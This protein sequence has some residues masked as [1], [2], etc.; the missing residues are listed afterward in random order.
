MPCSIVIPCYNSEKSVGPLVEQLAA[1]DMDCEVILVDDNSK[2]ET[3]ARIRE[4]T[5]KHDF[6]AGFSL[7]RNVGQHNALLVGIRACKHDTVITM[8]DDLQHNPQDIPR[9]I[10]VLDSGSDLVY[11]VPRETRQS[12]GRRIAS[13]VSKWTFEHILRM[14]NAASSSA[15][16]AF[17]KTGVDAIRAFSGGLVDIDAILSWGVRRV[18]YIVVEH[19]D[20]RFGASNYTFSKLFGHAIKMV[21]AYS[22]L[23]LL[24]SLF[25]G[26]AVLGLSIMMIFY[27]VIVALVEGTTV[28]GFTMLLCTI[29]FFSGV[30]IVMI[31][32]LSRYVGSIHSQVNGR[33]IA[34]IKSTVGR[35]S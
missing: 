31:G 6:I 32:I 5:A 1:L 17:S 33:P 35:V 30:Q 24:F 7:A 8:D 14:P 22:E 21:V 19:H 9:M 13:H 27:Y 34:V 15:F 4:L 3:W 2:D 11:C 25:L 12:I 10:E 26:M 18:D 28:P 29:L 23:P 16:R 20:R